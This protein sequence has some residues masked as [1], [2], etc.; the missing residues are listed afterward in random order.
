MEH[1]SGSNP[2]CSLMAVLRLHLA[3]QMDLVAFLE[4]PKRETAQLGMMRRETKMGTLVMEQ[5]VLEK[6]REDP[7]TSSTAKGET[8]VPEK[9]SKR[10]TTSRRHANRGGIE[11]Q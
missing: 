6:S 10:C 9:S 1:K 3:G 8:R 11:K 5:G 7:A 2:G 4:E